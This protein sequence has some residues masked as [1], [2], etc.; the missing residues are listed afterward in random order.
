MAVSAKAQTQPINVVCDDLEIWNYGTD[1]IFDFSSFDGSY[2][3]RFYIYLAQGATDIVDGQTY[4]LSDMDAQYS[5]YI[6]FDYVNDSSVYVDYSSV[7][8]V[9][10]NGSYVIDV[11]STEGQQYHITYTRLTPSDII[12]TVAVTMDNGRHN[13]VNDVTAAVG[14]FQLFGADATNQ[15]AMQ[16]TVYSDQMAGTYTF[17]DIYSSLTYFYANGATVGISNVNDFTVT[18]DSTACSAYI[19]IIGVDSV[20]YQVTFSYPGVI[21]AISDTIDITMNSAS[22]IF[23]DYISSMSLFR[24][25]G[26]DQT[27]DYELYLAVNSN[28]IAGSYTQDD[29]NMKYSGLYHNDNYVGFYEVSDFTVT[30]NAKSCS[31][32]VEIL[33]RDNILYRINYSYTKQAIVPTDTVAIVM[34]NEE[35]NIVYDHTTDGEDY[36]TLYG[37]DQNVEYL[38]RLGV[39]ASGQ[40]AGTYTQ[41]DVELE[42]TT[43]IHFTETDTTTVEIAEVRDFTVLGDSTGCSTYIEILSN[44]LVLYKITYTYGD[45]PEPPVSVEN[46][47]EPEFVIVSENNAIVVY[48]AAGE[49]IMV[50]DM[51]GRIIMNGKTASDVERINVAVPGVY[52][53]RIGN[54]AVNVLVK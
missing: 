28:Q 49:D 2:V 26:Y 54:R 31:T 34:D 12:D 35:V 15:Y 53:V 38:F 40:M 37:A 29:V 25:H 45:A 44:D 52:V 27:G 9:R 1:I 41:N 19:E 48:T 20:L 4:T 3:F 17:D 21:H 23:E 6:I 42:A 50:C 7:S 32:Y 51:T 8:F 18:G 22:N 43:L 30:G 24:L 46:V 39:Y 11:T 47:N 13:S 14:V 10:N 36:F 33:G 5:F 16:L